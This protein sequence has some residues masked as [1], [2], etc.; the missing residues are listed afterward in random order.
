V[1]KSKIVFAM[2]AG[3]LLIKGQNLIEPIFEDLTKI[4]GERQKLVG[5]RLNSVN[6]DRL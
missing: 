4:F 2:F 1:Y 5:R 6:R 3:E